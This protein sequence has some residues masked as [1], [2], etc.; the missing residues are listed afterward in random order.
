MSKK[1][2]T[3]SKEQVLWL[4]EMYESYNALME[5]TGNNGN[6]AELEQVRKYV[7]PLIKELE[8]ITK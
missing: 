4:R 1:S 7:L 5:G 2:I 8:K 3:V 6:E